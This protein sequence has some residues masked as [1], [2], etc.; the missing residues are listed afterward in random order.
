MLQQV[1]TK[2]LEIVKEDTDRTV[3]MTTIDS[4]FE[5]LEKI[6]RPVLEVQGSTGAI[7][8]R[9]KEA[10][11]HKVCFLLDHRKMYAGIQ[12]LCY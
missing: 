6:G 7:L 5:L 9:M 3:V 4:L 1:V 11:T 2:F 12:W 8:A 10:F